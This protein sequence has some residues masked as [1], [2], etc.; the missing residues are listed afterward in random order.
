MGFDTDFPESEILDVLGRA[1]VFTGSSG[2]V[3]TQGVIDH[4]VE[5]ETGGFNAPVSER[6]KVARLMVADVGVPKRG[7]TVFDV[8]HSQAYTVDTMIVNDGNI[9]SVTLI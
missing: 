2:A 8:E 6:K 5:L 3:S 9:V 4:D 7:D 1:I